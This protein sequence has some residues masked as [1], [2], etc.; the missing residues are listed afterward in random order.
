MDRNGALKI[1]GRTKDIIIRG[2]MN[3]YP[4]E[5]E[6]VLES[7]PRV[8]SAVVSTLNPFRDGS[9]PYHF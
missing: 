4:G 7:H 6:K 1:V 3:I 5:I 2:G 9:K 8:R